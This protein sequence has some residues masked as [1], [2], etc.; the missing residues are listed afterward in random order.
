METLCGPDRHNDTISQRFYAC[1]NDEIIPG[2]THFKTCQTQVFG[3]QL[4]TEANIDTVCANYQISHIPFGEY[5]LMCVLDQL[6]LGPTACEH[7]ALWKMNVC[8]RLVLG[9]IRKNIR[10]EDAANWFAN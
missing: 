9:P 5:F 3:V 7:S 6:S 1:F 8:H 10:S 2:A 4:D